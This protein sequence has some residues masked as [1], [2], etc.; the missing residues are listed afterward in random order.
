MH[1]IIQLLLVSLATFR[2]TR[3]VTQDT[4][5]YSIREWILLRFPGDDQNYT[6]QTRDKAHSWWKRD[7][8]IGRSAGQ[9]WRKPTFIGRLISCDYCISVWLAPAVYF[10]NKWNED[11]VFVIA[12]AGLV[13]LIASFESGRSMYE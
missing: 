5:T 10:L 6:W 1:N 13:Y 2:L 12:A 3:L 11:V 9:E 8:F 4:I 7:G